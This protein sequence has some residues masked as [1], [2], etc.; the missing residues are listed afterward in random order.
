[1]E[2]LI[3]SELE[4]KSGIKEFVKHIPRGTICAIYGNMGVGKTTCI[5]EMCRQLGVIDEVTS[6]TFAII[7]EYNTYTNEVIFHFD[8]Y[9]LESIEE[10]YNV[11]IEEYLYSGNTCFIEWPELIE[12]ILPPTTMKVSIEEINGGARKIVNK[13]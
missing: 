13:I 2:I 12:S 6:P 11:G 1:M 8:L 7:N 5:K 4:I 3:Q 9:R 10:A